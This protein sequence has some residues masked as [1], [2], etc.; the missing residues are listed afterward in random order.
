MKVLYI[1]THYKDIHVALFDDNGLIREQKLLDKKNNSSY[2]MPI[3]SEVCTPREIEQIVVV[4][5]PGSF[6]GVRLGVT[7][8]KTMAYCLN[9]P[10]KVLSYFDVLYNSNQNSEAIYAV[11]DNNGY[12]VKDYSID[13]NPRYLSKE[14]FVNE[15]EI[16][17]LITN[18]NINFKNLYNFLSTKE[19][20]NV[21]LVNPLYIKKIGVEK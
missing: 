15:F 19:E 13:Q 20:T 7:I 10:I 18:G 12:Y 4:N 17:K 21:H 5:G 11:F 6:T 3:I 16:N 1:D 9:V 14:E 8:A 2:I